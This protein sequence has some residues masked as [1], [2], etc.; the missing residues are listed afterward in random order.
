MPQRPAAAA[1]AICFAATAAL[2]TAVWS[3][4]ASAETFDIKGKTTTLEA[5]VVTSFDQPWAMTFLPDGDML[6][7]T[8]PG[9][10]FLTSQSGEKSEVQGTFEV[11]YGGQG[12]LGDVILHPQFAENNRIYLSYAETLDKG[13]TFG[14]AVVSATLDRSGDQP[15]LTNLTKIWTQEP[16]LPGQGHYS[17]RLAFG[18]DGHL[19][20]TSGDRQKQ[21][22]AQNID[23]ALGKVIRLNEDG[24]VPSDNPIQDQGELAKTYWSIGHRNLLGIAF[25]DAGRLWTHEM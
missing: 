8:R 11:A 19:F 25:D 4:P 2:I 14:A 5:E 17:H 18:P 16:K 13:A 21:R 6:V 22:P 10:L 23:Q 15:K 1:S 20:I 9:K 24:S 12:G 7:T 3:A